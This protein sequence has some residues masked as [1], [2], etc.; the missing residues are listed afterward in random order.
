[1]SKRLKLR[2]GSDTEAIFPRHLAANT[3]RAYL[4]ALRTFRAWLRDAGLPGNLEKDPETIAT[5]LKA[6]LERGA[7]I[8]SLEQLLKAVTA[9]HAREITTLQAEAARLHGAIRDAALEAAKKPS[10]ATVEPVPSTMA[11]IRSRHQ[12]APRQAAP[13]TA[14]ALQLIRATSR[15]PRITG[16]GRTETPEQADRRARFDLAI[17]GTMR[18]AML[19]VSEAAALR[20]KDV[21]LLPDGTAVVTIR[22][23]KTDKRRVGAVR[24]LGPPTVEDLVQIRPEPPDPDASLF[25]LAPASISRRIAAAARTAGLGDG[26]T[27]HSPRVGMA[28][29][30]R[31]NGASLVDLQDAGRWKNPSMPARYTRA[32]GATRGPVARLIYGRTGPGRPDPPDQPED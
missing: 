9:R 13:L 25:G 3:K 27:G 32:Q 2:S 19:R 23:S 1:M 11:W 31:A 28:Q 24:E 15:T 22:R 21:Q 16:S 7:G 20:W 8:D 26:F 6:A 29:D 10:P 17:I 12:A 30:L 4:Q 14:A 18:D 5:Y